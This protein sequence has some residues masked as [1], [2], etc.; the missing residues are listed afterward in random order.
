MNSTK[1][2]ILDAAEVLF[3]KKGYLLTSL[4]EVTSRAQ[5]NLAAVNYHFGSKEGLLKAVVK[6][7]VGP[8]NQE[9]LMRL[10]AL[11][12]RVEAGGGPPSLK[13]ILRAFVE[14]GLALRGESAM[15]RNFLALVGR[16]MAG[17]EPVTKK[18]FIEEMRPVFMLT[19]DLLSQALPELEPSELYLRFRFSIGSM[20]HALMGLVGPAEITPTGVE[21]DFTGERI[22][23]SLIAFM[24]AGIRQGGPCSDDG[25]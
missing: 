5:V 18:V 1:T 6:R 12:G 14:P 19:F 11:S 13:A 10:E 23:D 17:T 16:A 15:A 4:R 25:R 21:M 9:R 3:A 24:E 7:R 20:A 8:I 22:V 2:R